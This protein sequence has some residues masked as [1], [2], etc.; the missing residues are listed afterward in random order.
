MILRFDSLKRRIGKLQE[1]Y[2]IEAHP[3]PGEG[4]SAILQYAR[5]HAV[6]VPDGKF[7]E[8]EADT[9]M[10]RLLREALQ[11]QDAQKGSR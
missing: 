3:L 11:W 4:L 10:G 6:A 7:W 8:L 9:G 1:A 2:A 5:Q